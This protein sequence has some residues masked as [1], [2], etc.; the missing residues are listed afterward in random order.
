[1][2]DRI[3]AGVLVEGIGTGAD[4]IFYDP[5]WLGDLGRQGLANVRYNR[6]GS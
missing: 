5:F 3:Q 1:M 2:G 4:A 6:N